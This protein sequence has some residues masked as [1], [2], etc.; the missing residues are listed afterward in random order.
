MI[1]SEELEQ[2]R[3]QYEALKEDIEKQKIIN[4]EVMESIFRKNV[5]VLDSDRKLGVTVGIAAIPFVFA[6]CLLQGLDMWV[7]YALSAV[8]LVQVV[9][10][11]ILYR[12]LG[13][14][15]TGQGD[16]LD[17]ALRLREFRKGYVLMN[18][19][20]WALVLG[21]FVVMGI[22]IYNAW[23]TPLKG[24]A[25]VGIL[26]M[27]AIAGICPVRQEGAEGVRRDN[28]QTGGRSPRVK[29]RRHPEQGAAFRIILRDF[30][31]RSISGP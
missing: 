9:W 30:I 13:S 3:L 15:V 8:F 17:T 27:M 5:R 29:K 1:M 31:S 23:S 21:V 16:I 4:A 22:E 11:I 24:L 20:L 26:C 2:M 14:A 19:V 7:A 28:T 10:Y 6:V 12:R 18:T 25:A